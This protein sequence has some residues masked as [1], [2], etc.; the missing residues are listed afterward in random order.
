[1]LSGATIQLRASIDSIPLATSFANRYVISRSYVVSIKQLRAP[2]NSIPWLQSPS[3][4]IPLIDTLSP[5]ATWHPPRMDTMDIQV[6]FSHINITK[7]RI[8]TIEDVNIQVIQVFLREK[9]KEGGDNTRQA[10]LLFLPPLCFYFFEYP[11]G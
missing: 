2:P 4:V 3:N 6:R 1:M 9:K 5:I 10:V 8:N 7:V 11:Y